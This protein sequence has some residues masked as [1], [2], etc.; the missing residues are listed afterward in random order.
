MKRTLRTLVSLLVS[1]PLAVAILVG[2]SYYAKSDENI[3]NP[4]ITAIGQQVKPAGYDWREPVF[5]GLVHRRFTRALPTMAEALGEL[6][7]T[8]LRLDIPEGYE[9]DAAVYVAGIEVWSGSAADLASYQFLD[10]GNYLLQV[11]CRRPQTEDATVGWGSFSYQFAFDVTVEP[12]ME[13]SDEWVGQGDVMAIRLKN[14]APGAAPEARTI[15]GQVNFVPTGD[16]SMTGYV[17]IG[18]D[19]ETG[20][21]PVTV[22]VDRFSWTVDLRVVE[23]S[24]AV[25]NVVLPEE[26]AG[27]VL[28]ADDPLAYSATSEVI[29]PL[30]EEVEPYQHWSGIFEMPAKGD[31]ITGYGLI[32][33]VN[34]GRTATRHTGVDIG[35]R[36]G[37]AVTAPNAGVVVYTGSLPGCGNTVVVAHGG[38]L[39]SLF[40]HLS[41]ID[42]EE[43]DALVKGQSIGA[44]GQTGA[45]ETPHL[46]Y[47]V[48]MGAATLNP[49][50][51]FNGTSKLYYFESRQVPDA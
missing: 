7:E 8:H 10:N 21:Y 20:I 35:A 50:A 12:R 23:G 9:A 13:V 33:Y 46:H 51:L 31:I 28:N 2:L 16:G 5:G 24:F 27:R 43:G 39:K 48:R 6:N 47:E 4:A 30:L 3:P 36:W 44:V 14:L 40:F 19:C 32:R 1:I 38:G 26:E 15:L 41:E 42:V 25:Q 22:T 29:L 11:E 34:G 37:S 45:A 49:M 18:H 17:P